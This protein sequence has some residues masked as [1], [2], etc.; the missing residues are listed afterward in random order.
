MDLRDGRK[1][2]K[3]SKLLEYRREIVEDSGR[4]RNV[5]RMAIILKEDIIR[6][7]RTYSGNN[8]LFSIKMYSNNFSPCPI[9]L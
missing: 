9:L 6:K 8:L 5:V 3:W 1:D 7:R 2:L 4:C